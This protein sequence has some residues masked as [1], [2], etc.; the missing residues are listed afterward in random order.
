MRRS[1]AIWSSSE[2]EPIRARRGQAEDVVVE[3]P[4]TGELERDQPDSEDGPV[5][6]RE[7]KQEPPTK[8][9]EPR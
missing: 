1:R 4:V 5:R 9:G 8:A 2:P 3:A 6:R 7:R